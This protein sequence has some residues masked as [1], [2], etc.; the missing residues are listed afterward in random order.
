MNCETCKE[1]NKQVAKVNKE[2]YAIDIVA[3]MARST[4]KKLWVVII[5][6]IIL[7]A[8]SNAAWIYYESQF[9]DESWTY[10][11]SADNGSNAIANGDGEVYFNYGSKSAS[12]TYEE[13]AE[14]G[15]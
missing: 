15:R 6:L 7:L 4:I 13:G 14:D 3:A 1:R 8:A 11:A 2:Q 12:D 9:T 10:E 5:I